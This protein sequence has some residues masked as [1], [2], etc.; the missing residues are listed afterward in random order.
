EISETCRNYDTWVEEQSALAQR[1]YALDKSMDAVK[2]SRVADRDRLLKDLEGLRSEVGRQLTAE[3]IDLLNGW[4]AKVA[5]FKAP[6]YT[7]QVRGRDI[8]IETHTE[9]LS[10][11]MV[12]KIALPR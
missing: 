3:N 2:A 1:L 5:K 6:V 12:P 11:T 4:E 7:F 9:S 10:H 8:N